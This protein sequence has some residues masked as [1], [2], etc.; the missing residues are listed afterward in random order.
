MK[1]KQTKKTN[2]L[3]QSRVRT[4]KTDLK[5]KEK[6]KME[7]KWKKKKKRIKDEA[8]NVALIYGNENVQAKRMACV[9]WLFV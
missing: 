5:W 8:L 3:L 4:K 1:N 9:V 2:N 7:R 6:T